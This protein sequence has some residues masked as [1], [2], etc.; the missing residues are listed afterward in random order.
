MS[1]DYKEKAYE[2]YKKMNRNYKNFILK[3]FQESEVLNDLNSINT[4]LDSKD[5]SIP[6][7]EFW[8]KDVVSA[9]F[10][11][12]I[13]SSDDKD[14]RTLVLNFADYKEPGGKF[15]KGAMAQEEA[16][17][18]S[19]YLYNVLELFEDYY[20]YNNQH[21]NKGLYANRAIYIPQVG[22]LDDSEDSR[23]SGDFK[24]IDTL[25]CASPN[26]NIALKYNSF[27][28]EENDRAL[29]SR[30][31]YIV[32]ILNKFKVNTAILGA[33]GCGVFKQDPRRVSS[34]FY[35]YL[36]S[37]LVQRVI[38][39]IPD[40]RNYDIFKETYEDFKRDQKN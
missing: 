17:C 32:S 24:F 4:I 39:A 40:S 16:L 30:I 38:F 37:S 5:H 29:E 15:L 10:D 1:W 18:H 34:L 35:K 31:K 28:K 33:F 14:F 21:K 3:C 6:T 27:S 26:Y 13:E 36:K 19:S 11:K 20:E 23:D 25:S 7:F 12:T 22:Y 9:I 8:K 2:H